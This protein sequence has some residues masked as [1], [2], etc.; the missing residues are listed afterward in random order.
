ERTR[1]PSV[2]LVSIDGV[3]FARFGD[4]YSTPVHVADLPDYLRFAVL[5]TEDRR[6]YS[7]FGLDVIALVRAALANLKAGR[8]VQGASTLTQQIAK[9]VILTPERSFKHKVQELLLAF[10]LEQTFTKDELLSIYLNR[11]YLGAGTYGV[12]AASRRYF[13]KPAARL[14]MGESAM[15]A[16]LLKAPSRYAPTRDLERAQARARRVLGFMVA[17]GYIDAAEAAAASKA[18]FTIRRQLANSRGVRYFADW[19]FDRVSDY[20]G[21]AAADITVVTTL[22]MAMQKA[23]EAAVEWALAGEGTERQATQAALVALASDG[24]VRAMVGG[25]DYRVSQFNRATQA[26]RQPGSA[27]K[28]FVYLA[29]LEAGMAPTDMVD[30]APLTIDGWSPRNYDG[31][32][33]GPVTLKDALVR[34]LNTVAVRITEWVGRGRV[35]DVARRLGINSPLRADASLAL[36]ASE[37]TLLETTQAY[38]ALANGGQGV[39]AHGIDEITGPGGTVLY[40]RSGTGLGR[41]V[42]P[43]HLRPL[44]EMMSAVITAGTGRAARVPWPSAGKTG[45][46]QEWRDAWFVAFNRELT[47]GVWIGN[48]DGTPMK[49]VSGGGLPA[50]LWARFMGAALAGTAPR[51]LLT[52]PAE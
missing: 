46:S 14:T 50:R 28:P 17:A 3:Q 39:W 51:P 41:V 19:V 30:D 40:R 42:E 13:G 23:A 27:F 45:T 33:A 32:Y 48:D 9:N 15:I 34:S 31:K 38:T 29:A 37:A 43:V 35:V 1:T 12:G 44:V 6:F 22:D 21:P 25:R 49:W 47:A 18:P 52:G 11:V 5:A 10:W 16:G 20:T 24:A 7:H 26:R 2:R 36:G 8:V 4:A